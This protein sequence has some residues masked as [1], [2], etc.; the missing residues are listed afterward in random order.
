MLTAGL[1]S[2]GGIGWLEILVIATLAI[3]FLAM[4]FGVVFVAN[5]AARSPK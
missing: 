4:I 5:K 3:G 1:A 2:A